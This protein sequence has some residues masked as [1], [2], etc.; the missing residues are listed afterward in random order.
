MGPLENKVE[1]GQCREGILEEYVHYQKHSWEQFISAY[2]QF[3]LL[4]YVV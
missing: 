1:H 2:V 4:L 3:W